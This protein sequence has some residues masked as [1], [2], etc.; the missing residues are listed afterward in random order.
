MHGV[1]QHQRGMMPILTPVGDTEEEMADLWSQL[2][3]GHQPPPD[4]NGMYVPWIS[5]RHV[6]YYLWAGTEAQPNE[7]GEAWRFF[8]P[9][10]AINEHIGEHLHKLLTD[11][12]VQT[13]V[14][15]VRRH[16]DP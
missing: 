2:Q 8:W 1:Q 10:V 4:K 13:R 16:T 3:D 11:I 15:W 5:W 9:R 7:H 14:V 12:N 6:T